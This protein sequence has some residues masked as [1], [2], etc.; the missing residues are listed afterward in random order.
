M[1]SPGDRKFKVGL[2]LAADIE[3]SRVCL[4]SYI[5]VAHQEVHD[6]DGRAG[7]ELPFEEELKDGF[8][9]DELKFL[10]LAVEGID[11]RDD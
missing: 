10:H 8:G 9:V 6:S 3:V 2:E 11:A 1:R 4:L 5:T 7:F